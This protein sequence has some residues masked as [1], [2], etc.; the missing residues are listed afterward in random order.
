MTL[1][2]TLMLYPAPQPLSLVMLV[3]GAA[4]TAAGVFVWLVAGQPWLLAAGV[5]AA[6]VAGS[7]WPLLGTTA[8]LGA[9]LMAIMDDPGIGVPGLAQLAGAAWA[10]LV[11]LP[12]G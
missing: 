2:A 11:V 9:L 3:R 8:A 7:F 1:A 5:T 12:L 6:A 10:A 4:V